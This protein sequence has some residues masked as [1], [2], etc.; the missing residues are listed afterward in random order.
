MAKK[1]ERTRA[2]GTMTEAGFRSFIISA[3]RSKTLHWKPISETRKKAR[4]SKGL[5]RCANCGRAVKKVCI[6]HINP[7]V[8]Y[9]GF[10]NWD[11]YINN[12]FCEE[13]NLQA[14]CENCH[15]IKTKIEKELRKKYKDE[16]RAL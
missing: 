10:N 14:L 5:Y 1:I 12:M 16:G 8:G 3:L 2:S 9:S 11:S 4:I 13:G 6:D 7:I 15:A